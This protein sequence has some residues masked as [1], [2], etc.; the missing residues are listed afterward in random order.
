MPLTLLAAALFATY[1][2]EELPDVSGVVLASQRKLYYG[3]FKL[4]ADEA[5]KSYKV[6]E[7]Q[8]YR[9]T[10]GRRVSEPLLNEESAALLKTLIDG[11][12]K[13]NQKSFAVS[14]LLQDRWLITFAA[15]WAAADRP[16]YSYC[17]LD[18]QSKGT[19]HIDPEPGHAPVDPSGIRAA[20]PGW[21]AFNI[22]AHKGTDQALIYRAKV[23][24]QE[25]LGSG[26]LIGAD[27]RGH[28]YANVPVSGKPDPSKFSLGAIKVFEGASWSDFGNGRAIYVLPDG[29]LLAQR[30][31]EKNS[32]ETFLVSG[33]N[34]KKIEADWPKEAAPSSAASDGS[35]MLLDR[36]SS[37][38]FRAAVHRE[39][40]TVWLE[41]LLPVGYKITSRPFMAPDGVIL[42]RGS[43]GSK[44]KSFLIEP[45]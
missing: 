19:F 5:S 41:S 12:T 11:Q 42:V 34:W 26:E 24:R 22:P 27:S 28:L 29:T 45:R 40:K 8:A 10:A 1:H 17:V 38:I 30:P 13:T 14:G 39:G 7:L 44:A 32:T 36:A 21:V 33:G 16:F 9:R 31:G 18:T 35:I 15:A 37:G 4:N 43:I 3:A 2:V 20:G 25:L 23:G 6:D